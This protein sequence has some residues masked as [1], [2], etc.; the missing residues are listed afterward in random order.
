MLKKIFAFI[1]VLLFFGGNFI[2]SISGDFENKKDTNKINESGT[3][4]TIDWWPMFR[5]DL[6]H[7]GYS[8]SSGPNTNF[9]LWTY[10]TG[11]SIDSSPAVLDGRIYFG[12]RDYNVYCL[13]AATG[14][15]IW[16]YNIGHIIFCS[17]AIYE[18]KIYIGSTNATGFNGNNIYC[19]DALTGVKIWEY[20]TGDSY[21][22]IYSSP[23]VEDGKVYVGSGDSKVYCLD[24][25]TGIKYWEFITNAEVCSS[26]AVSNGKVYIGSQN[27][28]IYCLNASTGAQIWIYYTQDQIVSSPTIVSGKIYIGSDKMYCLDA[29]TGAYI[30]SRQPIFMYSS[31]AVYNN[32][33]YVCDIY[34][35]I[36]CFNADNGMIIWQYETEGY[37]YNMWSS[38]AITQDKVYIGAS[39]GK[40]YCL[41]AG[42][43][44]KIWEYSTGYYPIFSSPAIAGGRVYIGDMNGI[45]YCFG[46]L[47][48]PPN[49][50]NIYGPDNGTINVE[51][52]FCTDTI[53]D[54]EGDS[55]YCLWD[56]GDGNI[57]GWLGPYVSGQIICTNNKWTE[58]GV[59][60]I[61][62]KLKDDYGMESQ[63]SD[64][65]CITIIDNLPP[66]APS[67]DG[68]T[69]VRVGVE[70]SWS[71]FSIDPEGNNITYYVDWG[72]ECGGAEYHGPYPSGQVVNL[73]HK[74]TK[75]ITLIINALAI[76]SNDAESNLSYFD[77]EI[78]RNKTLT[79]NRFLDEIFLQFK[80]AFIILRHLI[81][82]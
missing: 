51:Y 58:P 75:K 66:S 36:Y 61:K 71:F 2:S 8:A 42:T 79:N 73:S 32:K 78:S 70:K 47:N 54:P 16:Q 24:A 82:I 53:T 17:P 80:S 4:S 68:P 20:A 30:W 76:D 10:T 74:Y 40:L 29:E 65:F 18:N 72:D 56:W 26:P 15:K 28:N 48:D 37:G 50:P 7:S 27:G 21:W 11:N 63:W 46:E 69:H 41:N 31:P 33:V 34:D 12:S 9:S 38:P 45:M 57:S 3:L 62:L 22:G 64:P 59:Y 35:T 13:N 25:M 81:K 52:T 49:K 77:V 6:S 55:V 19:L 43:G 23:A 5:H 1:I 67:I 44:E 39:D 14:E 60:C